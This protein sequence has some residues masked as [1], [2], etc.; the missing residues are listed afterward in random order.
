MMTKK[1]YQAIANIVKNWDENSGKNN[2][3]DS[4]IDYMRYDNSAFNAEKFRE[5]CTVQVAPVKVKHRTTR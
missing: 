3:I 4:L 1:H 2:L 5:A